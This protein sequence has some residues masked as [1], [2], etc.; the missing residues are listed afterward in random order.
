M[1][2]RFLF[3]LT[4]TVSGLVGCQCQPQS[5]ADRDNTQQV[6]GP[7]YH[8]SILEP[9]AGGCIWLKK[10]LATKRSETMATLSADCNRGEIS[11]SA[12]RRHV[13]LSFGEPDL[14]LTIWELDLKESTIIPKRLPI[15]E[16]GS[17][18]VLAIN[19]TGD[20]VGF[21]LVRQVAQMSG[22][23][24]GPMLQIDGAMVP[25]MADGP[26]LHAVAQ[27][28]RPSEDRW[29][30]IDSKPTRCCAP[31]ALGL[32]ALPAAK[33]L[34]SSLN[35]AQVLSRPPRGAPITDPAYL[36][37]LNPLLYDEGRPPTAA[38]GRWLMIESGTWRYKFAHYA[39]EHPHPRGHGLARLLADG[40][41]VELPEWPFN[42]HDLVSIQVLGP[43]LMVSDAFTGA[44]PVVYDMRRG[45][46]AYSSQVAHAAQFWP[47]G[48]D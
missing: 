17:V 23:E 11:W 44:R 47:A 24:R 32:A 26:G 12:D 14:G 20:V 7:S 48:D 13:V 10:N 8:L 15:P 46:L 43:Y 35:S 31:G 45:H 27:T 25:A 2:L 39:A 41:A 21:G 22:D 4:L 5:A 3:G 16:P 42:V 38:T 1:S 28:L 29:D 30:V 40:K 9:H 37:E 19:S 6:T 34:K 33:I 18:N 36:A